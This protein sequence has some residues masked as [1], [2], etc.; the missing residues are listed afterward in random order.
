MTAT[1]YVDVAA[2]AAPGDRRRTVALFTGLMVGLLLSELD[3]SVF[4]T[5]LP[6][7]VGDLA[8]VDEMLWVTTAYV[9]A[10]TVVMPVYGLLGDRLGR[11]PVFLAALVAF[12]LGS[13]VGGL[14]PDMTWLIVGRAVQGLGGGGLLIL[15]QAIVADVVPARRRAPYM[16][17]VGAVF[18]LAALLGP[19]LGGWFTETIGW[20][21]V[22][23]VNLPLGGIA[24]ALAATLLHL[25]APGRTA[26]RTAGRV[27]VWGITTMAATV[28]AL[29]LLS[30]W[31]GTR[32]AWSSPEVAVTAVLGA[33]ALA[34]FV[35]VERRAAEPLIPWRFFAERSFAAATLAGLVMAVALFGTVGYVPTYLQMVDGLS[36]TASGVM[37]LTLV[38]G[39]ALTT[40][41]SAQLVS[42]TGRY[43]GLP[44][45][46][47]LTAAA[48]LAL[49]STLTP[50]SG[51]RTVGAYLF[52]LGAG[53]GCALEIL[54][55]IVQNA[56]PAAQVGTATA[57]SSFFREI[58]V[59]LGTAVVGTLFTSRLGALLATRLPSGGGAGLDPRS[60]TPELV[61]GLSGPARAAVVTAYNDALTPVFLWLVPLLLL[62]VAV[63]TRVRPVPLGTTV[64]A[65]EPVEEVA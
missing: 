23:W 39:L 55:I 9:L 16:S 8:G 50:D 17:A 64:P 25:P 19:V 26:G 38:A 44:V 22:F 11:K 56:T 24:I 4:A 35:L 1:A 60:L 62:S 37:M 49:M 54:V 63:L 5:A 40:V 18:A 32:Y 15:V 3:Q 20:R 53:M 7:V 41:G 58:G 31:G 29:V 28:T 30:S 6:T 46:G 21:W 45:A 57:T 14:A 10:A 59:S 33:A 27:D 13:L 12:V 52:L 34:A 36:A 48:A 42:R 61:H 2:D 43:R 47:A 65:A 51:L